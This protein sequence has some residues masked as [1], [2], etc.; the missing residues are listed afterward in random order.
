MA[1]I[2]RGAVRQLAGKLV[3]ARA[4]TRGLFCYQDEKSPGGKLTPKKTPPPGDHRELEARMPLECSSNF[5]QV[6]ILGRTL[7]FI[8]SRTRQNLNSS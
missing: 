3:R 5:R 1:A 4:P 6:Q 7:P 2:Y 8:P